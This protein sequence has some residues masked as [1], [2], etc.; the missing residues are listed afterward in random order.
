MTFLKTDDYFLCFLN[1]CFYCH[2]KLVCNFY[3]HLVHRL[4]R[5]FW[6]LRSKR[7]WVRVSKLTIFCVCNVGFVRFYFEFFVSKGSPFQ[8]FD[9]SQQIGFSKNPKG[10]PFPIFGIVR[11]FSARYIRVFFKTGIFPCDF[12]LICSYR[13]PLDFH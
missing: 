12:F 1:C 13:N 10:P 3:C 6:G 11:F 9:I 4:I 2:T 5:I 8:F 7:T